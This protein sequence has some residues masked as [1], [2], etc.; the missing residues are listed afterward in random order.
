MALAAKYAPHRTD[1]ALPPLRVNL[2][3][4]TQTKPSV[5]MK[6]A[7][8][9]AEVGDEQHG[10]D[11]A[12]HELCDRMAALTGK[13][14]AVF[15]PSGTMCNQ[16]AILTHCRA[17][18]EILA[19]ELSHIVA[20]EGGGPGALAG[21]VV[22]GLKGERGQFDADTVRAALREPRRNAPPQT[23][24]E[25]EQTANSGGG[26]VWPLEKLNA[27]MDVAHAAGMRTHMDGARLMNAVVSAGVPAHEMAARCDS[28]WLDFTK[29]LG[30]PLGA[31]LCGSEAFIDQAWRWK[32]RLGG[33]LRQGGI[34]AAACTYALDHNVARLAEDHANARVLARGLAQIPGLVVEEPETNLV[35]FD[36]RGAGLTADELADRIRWEGVQVS[37]V[38]KYRVR[39]C[40][41][42]DVDRVGIDL[43]IQVIREKTSA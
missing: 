40:T 30:A 26:S 33:S 6:E 37:T 8:M 15:L 13:E 25:V 27:V 17:G 12:I 23:L 39:A 35:F 1:P 43:A 3:S 11:L 38:G 28:V 10:D 22:L 5:A 42:L 19:H 36:T 31:V 14:A 34:C 21:A 16:I 9:A 7:M 32:Q 29:G 20:N 24:L 18:D 2:Y 4:D 41:H